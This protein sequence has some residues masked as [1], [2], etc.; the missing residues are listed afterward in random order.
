MIH[1]EIKQDRIIFSAKSGA[2]S[3]HKLFYPIV[4]F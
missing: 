2:S 3:V 4:L 1:H